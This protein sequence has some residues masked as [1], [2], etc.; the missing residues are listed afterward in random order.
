MQTTLSVKQLNLYVR[1]LLEGDSR[2]SYVS[3]SGEISNFKNHY[4]SGHL[5]FSLK[6]SDALINCAMFRSNASKLK[7]EL[8]DGLAVIC[9]G[10]VSLYE[11]S[12][13]YQLYV[14]DI[15]PDGDGALALKFQQIKEKLEK[16]GLFDSAHKKPLPAFPKT[17][18]S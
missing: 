3:V 1:S 5:Y 2:L 14:E 16:Q 18:S 6:D 17:K 10:R 9:K 7:C 8:S 15:I 4:G 12:G 11:K 13:Q